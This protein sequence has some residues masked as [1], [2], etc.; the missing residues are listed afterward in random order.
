M[1]IGD[2]TDTVTPDALATA[3]AKWGLDAAPV[4]ARPSAKSASRDHLR[5][6][7][8]AHPLDHVRACLAHVPPPSWERDVRSISPISDA[9]SWLML[10]WH[11][12]HPERDPKA[13]EKGRWVLYECVPESLIPTGKRLLL[14]GKP[15][16]EVGAGIAKGREQ[17]VSAFQWEMF[18]RYRVEARPFWIIQGSDG[19]TPAVYSELEQ[20][21]FLAKGLPTSPPFVGALPF[22][23]WDARAK[24]AVLKRDA[25]TKVGGNIDRLRGNASDA[26]VQAEFELAEQAYR[27]ELLKWWDEQLQEQVELM[28]WLTTKTETDRLVRRTT[29][30]ESRAADT[31]EEQF[32][33]H[34]IVPSGRS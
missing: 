21:L 14:A 32:V 19:G 17:M 13:K 26:A 3:R 27:A 20:R 5:A 7:V 29:K 22:A 9:H 33:Q 1:T 2:S 31:L 6:V 10:T 23:P 28:A 16:W 18:R 25:L 24:R 4:A 12:P 30:A 8:K 11:E 15:Y 34:G